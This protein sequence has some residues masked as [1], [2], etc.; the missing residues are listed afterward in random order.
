MRA[1][2]LFAFLASASLVCGPIGVRADPWSGDAS[3]QAYYALTRLGFGPAGNDVQRVA[4]MGVDNYVDQQLYPEK[5][6]LPAN[7]Q[8]QLDQLMTLTASPRDL[9]VRDRELAAQRKDSDDKKVITEELNQPV[10]E[11]REAKLLRAVESP[12]QLQEALVDFWYNHFNVYAHKEID[13]IFVGQYEEHAIRPFVLGHFRDM[14]EATA[15][16]P[17]MLYYL[18]NWKNVAPG[19]RPQR[20]GKKDEEGINENYAREVMELHTLGVDGG[21][22][23]SD[24]TQLAR[25]LSGWGFGAGQLRQ[26]GVSGGMFGGQQAVRQEVEAENHS[27]FFFN[28]DHHDFGDKVFLNR[29]FHGAGQAEGEAALDMLAYSPVTA[30]HLSYELAQYFVADDPP[31]SLVNRM[32]AEWMRTKG[33]LR[34]VTR[35]MLKS[36]EFWDPQYRGQKYRTPFQYVVGAVRASDAPVDTEVLAGVLS[37]LGEEPYG[38][39]TPDGYKNT[40]DAWLN[41]GATEQRLTF[42]TALGSGKLQLVHVEHDADGAV[43]KGRDDEKAVPLDAAAIEATLAGNFSPTTLEAVN[44]ADLPLKAAMILG[45]P[46]MMRR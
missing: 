35:T 4:Q 30:K 37:K 13:R 43:V 28:S 6:P 27:V 10:R 2:F 40:I 34:A 7:L 23:Q 22:T 1:G 45:S 8:A 17:A 9:F 29:T 39:L 25:I 36:Q 38:C 44:S 26:R 15:K 31:A 46:E 24:V 12:R 19:S 5:I 32:T 14:L 18:D 11:A 3:E 41:S 21:Y 33:D 42:A 16:D 20:G